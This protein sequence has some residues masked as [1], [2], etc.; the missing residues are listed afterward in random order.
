MDRT[1][2][3]YSLIAELRIASPH[4]RTVRQLAERF[5]VGPRTVERDIG[6]LRKAGFPVDSRPGGGYV[7]DKSAGSAPLGLGPQ[8]MLALAVALSHADGTPF[9]REARS[10]LRKILAVMPGDAVEKAG[11]L[12]VT[13]L[14]LRTTAD[15][16]FPTAAEVA[17][18]AVQER[19]VLRIEYEKSGRERTVR[20]VEPHLLVAGSR[21]WFLIGWCRMREDVRS[22]RIDRIRSASLKEERFPEPRATPDPW[23]VVPD[24]V[25]AAPGGGRIIPE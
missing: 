17:R 22:F 15:P 12:A 2:R 23:A 3:L 21:G 7:L 16:A 1:D 10:A 25:E 5:E 9:A 19:R 13:S 18:Q 14:L 4:P 20:E 6:Y 8:E 11:G 24:D